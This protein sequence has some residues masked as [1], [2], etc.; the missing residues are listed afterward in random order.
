MHKWCLNKERYEK[1]I[2]VA[3]CCCHTEV[4]RLIFEYW[5]EIELVHFAA[6]SKV[7]TATNL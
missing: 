1:P 4:A 2:C 6:L 7:G 5:D 3:R